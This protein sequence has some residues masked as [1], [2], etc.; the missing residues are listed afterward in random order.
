MVEILAKFGKSYSDDLRLK[1][2]GSKEQEFVKILHE[3]LE[4]PLSVE[5]FSK[6]YLSH[7]TVALVNAELKPGRSRFSY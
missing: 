6:E 1:A 4:L 5:E 7:F 3:E 2:M